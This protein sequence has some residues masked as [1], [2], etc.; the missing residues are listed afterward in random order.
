M[1]EICLITLYADGHRY[2]SHFVHF[3]LPAQSLV[4]QRVVV[5]AD[6]Y[7][8]PVQVIAGALARVEHAD[9]GFGLGAGPLLELGHRV[10]VRAHFFMKRDGRTILQHSHLPKQK[11]RAFNGR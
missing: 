9:A 6:E 3:S 10:T 2:L 5:R 4:V 8:L 7:R 11:P 1:I